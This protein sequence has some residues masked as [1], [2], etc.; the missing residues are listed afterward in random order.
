MA[1][2]IT[3]KTESL[4]VRL[5]VDLMADIRDEAKETDSS[6][7]SVVIKRARPE[8][9]EKAGPPVVYFLRAGE[10]GPVKIGWSTKLA[11]RISG[12]QTG[13]P[14]KLLLLRTIECEPWVES[15]F[16]GQFLERRLVGEWFEFDDAM[17]TLTPPQEKPGTVCFR[18]I[19]PPLRLRSMRISDEMWKDWQTRASADN[20]SVTAMIIASLS[21]DRDQSAEIAILKQTLEAQAQKI[22]RLDV[23]KATRVAGTLMGN[24]IMKDPVPRNLTGNVES[25]LKPTKGKANTT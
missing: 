11:S 21:D 9:S 20:T 4:T 13:S 24:P 10:D 8:A 5:P 17:L 19:G 16:H 1:K 22:Q 6:I 2:A 12:I 23:E 25:R 15:W 18:R 7:A 14:V 3:S